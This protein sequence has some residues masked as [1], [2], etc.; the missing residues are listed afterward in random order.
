M[1]EDS[2]RSVQ[3]SRVGKAIYTATNIRGGSI[4]L[5]EGNDQDFSPVEL[6]LV[7]IAGCAAIDVDYITGKRAEP[8]TFEVRSEG[9]KVRDDNGNHLSNLKVALNVVFP[10]GAE[11]DAARAV[12]PRAIAQSHDRLCTVSRTVQLGTPVSMNS[13]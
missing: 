12:L 7:A 4:T 9:D 5:G 6:L 13:A 1:S 10:E 3:L 8:L 2:L 11:G